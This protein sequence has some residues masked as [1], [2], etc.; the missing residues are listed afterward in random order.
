MLTKN[1]IRRAFTLVELLV[2]IT[3][4]G[5]LVALL[6]PAVQA[7]REAARRMQCSTNLKQFT[8]GFLNHHQVL[9]YYPCGGW[10]YLCLGIPD[11]G[12]GK[13]QPGDWSYNVLPFIEQQVL[14]DLGADGRR[15]DPISTAKRDACVVRAQTPLAEF[16]CPS[17]RTAGVFVITEK[18]TLPD[19]ATWTTAA[20]TDYAVNGGSAQCDDSIWNVLPGSYV[21]ASVASLTAGDN[22]AWPALR[23]NGICATHTIIR[24]AEVRDGTSNTYMIGDKYLPVD[25]YYDGINGGDSSTNFSGFDD[26]RARWTTYNRF[27]LDTNTSAF[28]EAAGTDDKTLPPLQDNYVGAESGPFNNFGSAH[29]SGFNM[30]FCDGSVHTINFSVDLITHR[31]LGNRHDGLPIDSSKY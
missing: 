14:H 27:D 13:E 8:L 16:N 3:I 23:V 29:R 22:Y 20:R 21:G 11:R 5:I 25:H 15:G 7:A 4:I 28:I 19:G 31:R 2:V 17:R 26:D 6:L 10:G 30:A 24:D 18:P 9:G 1:T 12:S